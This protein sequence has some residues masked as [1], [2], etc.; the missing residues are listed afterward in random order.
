MRNGKRVRRI[1]VEGIRVIP[2]LPQREDMGD[3]VS[4]AKSIKQRGDVDVPIKVRP[5]GDGFYE[6]VW[7]RR[8]LEAA[9]IAGVKEITCIVEELSDE[10]VIRQ[11]AIENL[12]RKDK[13]PLEEAE[14]FQ[15]WSRKTGKTYDEIAKSLGIS[16]KYIYNRVELLGLAPEVIKKI[17]MIS[18][19]RKIGLLPLLYLHKIRDPNLQ[20]KI[21]NEFIEKNW[22]VNE[23][24]KRIDEVLKNREEEHVDEQP[25]RSVY[26]DLTI[27]LVP[28]D[29]SYSNIS[30]LRES[31]NRPPKIFTH[32]DTPSLFFKDGKTI[33]Q[34][35]I[36][37]FIGKCFIVDVRCNSPDE[38]ITVQRVKEILE[39]HYLPPDSMV[40]LYTGWFRYCG[41]ERYNE[42]PTI[43]LG[44]AEW[45]VEKR[46]RI[47]GMDMPNPER[48]GKEVHKLLL[49]NDILILE[50]LADM[51][52]VAGKK[53]TAYALPINIRQ[54]GVS[55][56]RVTVRLRTKRKPYTDKSKNDV[57]LYNNTPGGQVMRG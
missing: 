3:L 30:N 44:L 40:F 19:D 17:N 4:L 57:K 32:F 35:P 38:V 49:S 12:L 11:N 14:F 51:S 33:D 55:P 45:L 29:L 31:E 20:K 46:T 7:G 9:K 6:L 16:P 34:Y 22:T 54:G 41:T 25:K 2:W 10:D 56:A 39:R 27:P 23:L 13:N 24:R 1:P 37:W 21:F 50:N 18:T 53:V 15:F 8:R 47:L 5:V 26:Y 48:G 52:P 42:H 43:D 36:D 28:D